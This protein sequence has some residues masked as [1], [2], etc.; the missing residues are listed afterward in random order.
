MYLGLV[1]TCWT[2]ARVNGAVVSSENLG[3]ME[4]VGDFAFSLLVRDKPCRVLG[5][6]EGRS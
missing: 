6:R 5:V 4:M 3:A 2:V 1:S